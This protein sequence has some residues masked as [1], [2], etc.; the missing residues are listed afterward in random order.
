MGIGGWPKGMK[1]CIR[2]QQLFRAEQS[3]D[4]Y[5]CADCVWDEFIKREIDSWKK[6]KPIKRA[7]LPEFSNPYHNHFPRP[8]NWR[9]RIRWADEGDE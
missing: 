6:K 9:D 4:L 1:R 8:A 5:Q 3:T 7:Q 2:C